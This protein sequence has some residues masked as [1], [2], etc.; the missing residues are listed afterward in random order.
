MT[1]IK[2]SEVQSLLRKH[3]IGTRWAAE[4][5]LVNHLTFRRWMQDRPSM[6]RTAWELLKL[7]LATLPDGRG[8]QEGPTKDSPAGA[9][10]QK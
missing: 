3:N 9:K 1:R 2:S 10:G 7:K 4:L 5:C 6:P 8:N